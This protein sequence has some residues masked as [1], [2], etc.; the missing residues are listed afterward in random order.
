[1]KKYIYEATGELTGWNN[2][3][4]IRGV[5]EHKETAVAS[6]EELVRL[7]VLQRLTTPCTF[8]RINIHE[9]V[10]P[11]FMYDS[12]ANIFDCVKEWSWERVLMYT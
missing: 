5:L 8:L 9:V 2:I 6:V 12:T 3:I 1:M 4:T 10:S 11:E 7:D